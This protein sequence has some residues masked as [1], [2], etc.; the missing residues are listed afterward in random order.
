MNAAGHVRQELVSNPAPAPQAEDTVPPAQPSNR[1]VVLTHHGGPDRLQL[2][3]EAAPE[4][5]LGQ[6]RVR[7]L[8][9]GVSFPD[10]ELREGTYPG[11]PRPP[12]TLGYELA[13]VVDQLG[14]GVTGI[15]PGQLVTAM[16]VTGSYADYLCLPAADA[17]P[18]PAGIAPE[19][20]V[21]LV[22]NYLTAYQLL[23]RAARVKQGERVL[24][25]GA[26]GNVG[27]AV[28]QL[29]RLAGLDGIGGTTSLGSYQALR[30]GGRLILF[31]NHATLVGGRRQ[32][33]RV[34]LFYLASGVAVLGGLLPG[35]KQVR[36]Y[37]CADLMRRRPAWFQQD[38]ARLFALLLAGRITPTIAAQLPLE[39]ARR[40]HELLN[41]GGVR[42]KLVLRCATRPPP[43]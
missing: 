1:R 10:V 6:I 12:F 21:S 34:L 22:L 24:V 7:I 17:V 36:L 39:E 27:A 28:L 31:G 32:L 16:T 26:A 3:R 14:D 25:Q 9:A 8:V 38:M 11:G 33:R 23:H 5:G 37:H 15:R 29:G 43:S 35:G 40:A 13:G 42:G 18:V 19:L 2:V 4:P 30:P 41:A 20:A